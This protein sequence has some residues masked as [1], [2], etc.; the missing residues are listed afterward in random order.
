MDCLFCKIVAGEIPSTKMFE[1]DD[2]IIIKDIAPQA[3]VHYLAI[4]KKHFADITEMEEEDVALVGR[5]IKKIGEL[6]PTFGLDAGFRVVTNKGDNGRQ[7]VHHLHLH[8]LGG[9]K[10]SEKMC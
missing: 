4:P 9:E 5:M 8:I 3:P 7:S 6:A 1:N 2:M 10:L